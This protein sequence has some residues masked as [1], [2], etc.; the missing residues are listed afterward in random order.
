M[1]S[2]ILTLADAAQWRSRLSSKHAE[3]HLSDVEVYVFS[4]FVGYVAAKVPSDE[5][6]HESGRREVQAAVVAELTRR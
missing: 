3:S 5:Y 1:I 2:R 4:F 6:L